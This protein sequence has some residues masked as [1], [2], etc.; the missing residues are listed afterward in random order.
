MLGRFLLTTLAAFIAMLAK[1]WLI[2]T[3]EFRWSHTPI[4]TWIG[5]A[6]IALA[7]G[8]LIAI[9]ELLYNFTRP[10]RGKFGRREPISIFDMWSPGL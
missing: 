8:L 2:P 1:I 9:V 10:R 5:A 7:F 4:S 3:P 6:L